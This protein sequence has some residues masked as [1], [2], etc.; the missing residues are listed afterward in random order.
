MAGFET[1][2]AA[3]EYD[4]DVLI[5]E[6]GF[7]YHTITELITLLNQEGLGRLLKD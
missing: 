7:S 4:A 6:Y 2:K 1:L 5:K 3:L